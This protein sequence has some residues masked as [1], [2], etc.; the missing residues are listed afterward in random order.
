M[1]NLQDFSNRARKPMPSVVLPYHV[2]LSHSHLDAKWVESL[3]IRLTDDCAFSVW[4]DRWMMVPGASSWQQEISRGL[5][6]TMTC[7]VCL[8]KET[9]AGWFRMV[10]ELALNIQAQRPNF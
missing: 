9:P 2:F 5:H 7:A 4:L 3:A 8:G 1:S 6:E 10:I